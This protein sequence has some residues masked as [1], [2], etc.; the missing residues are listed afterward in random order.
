MRIVCRCRRP[1]QPFLFFTISCQASL[2]PGRS[3][4]TSWQYQ[5][6]PR[7]V[8]MSA[9]PYGVSDSFQTPAYSM[10]RIRISPT[11]LSSVS[12]RLFSAR[13]CLVLSRGDPSNHG[14]AGGS[15]SYIDVLRPIRDKVHARATQPAR[16]APRA[17]IPERT[18]R[19]ARNEKPRQSGARAT[20]EIFL[21]G[22]RRYYALLKGPGAQMRRIP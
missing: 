4:V 17:G 12:M 5:S 19:A 18:A 14:P 10:P 6:V 2:V 9:G 11:R 15:H 7:S 8:Q 21:E 1:V 16:R 22:P 20:S 13:H 3:C